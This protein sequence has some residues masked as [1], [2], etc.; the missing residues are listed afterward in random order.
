MGFIPL[1]IWL[2]WIIST[3]EFH[4]FLLQVKYSRRSKNANETEC[5][6]IVLWKEE[7]KKRRNSSTLTTKLRIFHLARFRNENEYRKR[8]PQCV[9]FIYVWF[10]EFYALLSPRMNWTYI[11]ELNNIEYAL[12]RKLCDVCVVM[13][14]ARYS[15]LILI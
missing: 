5:A 9:T 7:R 11:F 14:L 8:G 10:A 12:L 3:V 13:V 4:F 1:H 2:R 15:T 6:K